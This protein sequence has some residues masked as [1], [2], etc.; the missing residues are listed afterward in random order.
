MGAATSITISDERNYVDIWEFRDKTISL[1][2]E[3]CFSVWPSIRKP[4]LCKRALRHAQ[5]RTGQGL[6][7]L[8]KTTTA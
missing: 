1:A 2:L 7:E 6:D 5:L 4:A 3:I 8:Q